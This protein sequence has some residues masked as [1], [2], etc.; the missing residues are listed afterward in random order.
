MRLLLV[1]L[2]LILSKGFSLSV[3]LRGEISMAKKD[4]ILLQKA[5]QALYGLNPSGLSVYP[6]NGG[7]SGDHLYHLKISPQE[8]VLRV[9]SEHKGIDDKKAECLAAKIA[10][11]LGIGPQFLYEHPESTCF[12]TAYAEG[13]PTS[14]CTFNEAEAIRSL[15]QS[16]KRLHSVCV[17]PREWSVFA[18][19]RNIKPNELSLKQALALNYLERIEAVLKN[20]NFPKHL[21]HNDIQPNNL[22]MLKHKLQM[23]DWGDAG[24]ADP[25]WDLARSSMEFA[26][27]ASQDKAFL[28]SYLGTVNPLD[29]S[30]FRVMKQVF[31]LRSAFALQGIEGEPDA[32]SQALILKI[33]ENNAYPHLDANVIGTW[34]ALSSYLLDLFLNNYVSIGFQEALNTIRQEAF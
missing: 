14:H 24:K 20:A 10:S 25:Y 15:A 30:R 16:L 27:D 29:Q 21:C 9:H 19:I 3:D 8:A 23:I 18:Y 34:N 28:E 13:S 11:D 26:F 31:L 1:G 12:V 2:F 6:L 4:C 17:F 22:F 32:S 7:F 5:T 33:L